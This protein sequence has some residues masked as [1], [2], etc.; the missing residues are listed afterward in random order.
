[1]TLVVISMSEVARVFELIGADCV[2]VRNT[3]EAIKAFREALDKGY[4]VLVLDEDVAE[5]VEEMRVK[6]FREMKEPPAYMVI[7]SFTKMKGIRLNQLY[8][9]VS[10]AVG[11]RLRWQS[12]Q[13]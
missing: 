12:G 1:M 10:K 11:V 3:D 5:L 2:I 7:P 6:I 13:S 4:D 8:N 9:M